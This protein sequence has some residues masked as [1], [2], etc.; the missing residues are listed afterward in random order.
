ML[1]IAC[2][3]RLLTKADVPSS[4][5]ELD[6]LAMEEAIDQE[7]AE[8]ATAE[9]AEAQAAEAE[10]ADAVQVIDDDEAVEEA[11]P[12]YQGAGNYEHVEEDMYAEL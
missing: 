9:A 3:D 2:T 1:F 10:A 4:V 6:I 12:V 5:D 8:A 11:V 7:M